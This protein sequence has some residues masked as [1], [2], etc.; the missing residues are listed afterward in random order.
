MNRDTR[1]LKKIIFK[2]D[3]PILRA[4]PDRYKTEFTMTSGALFSRLSQSILRSGLALDTN[5]R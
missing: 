3:R 5:E 1:A 4:R 2:L